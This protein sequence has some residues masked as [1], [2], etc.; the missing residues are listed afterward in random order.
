ML[1]GFVQIT[2]EH[3]QDSVLGVHFSVVV[4][5]VDLNLFLELLG[6]GQSEH[7]APMR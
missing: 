4:L 6:L 1:F 5:L 2:V 3:L 7:L